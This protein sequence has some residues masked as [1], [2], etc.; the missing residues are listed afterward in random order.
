MAST[1]LGISEGL[2]FLADG[3]GMGERMRAF[4][5]SCSPLGP[6]QAWP[7]ALKTA[8][9]ILLTSKFPMFLAWGPEL[10]FLYNDAYV[11]VLGDKHPAALGHAFEDVW[12]EIW[13]EVGPLARRAL[14]GEATFFENLPL[15]MT[16]KGYEEQTWFTFSYSPLRDHDGIAAGIFCVCTETTATVLA[17]RERINE[18]ERLRQLFDRAPGFMAVV[19]GPNH[20]FEMANASYQRL[21]GRSDLIGK[22]VREAVPEVEGQGLFELLDKVYRSGEAFSGRSVNIS[23]QREPGAPREERLLDFVFQPIFDAQGAV[24]GIF[25]DGYDVTERMLAETAL[26]ESEARFRLIADSAPVPMWVTRLDRKRG[27]VNIAYAEFLGVPYEEALDF[28]WRDRIHP[29]D[30]DQLLAASIAGEAT[31]KLFTLEGRYRRGDGEWRWLRSISQPRWGPQGE[32]VGFIGVAIDI[33]EAKEAE[34]ALREVN[35]TLERR[36][37]ERTADLTAA[38]DRLQAEVGERLKAEEALRQAQKMEAVGQLTGGIAHDFNNLLTPIMGGLELIASRVDEPRLKRIAETA[39]ESTRR[40]AKLTGQ[41]LAFSRIQRISMGPVAV[42]EVIEAMRRLLRHTLGGSV[43]IDTRL[44]P[45]AGHGVCD[46]NQ[47]ENAILNLAINARDAMPDGGTLT[48]STD[49]VRLGGQPDHPAGEFVRITVRDTGTGMAADVLARATEP[50]YSTKPLGKGTGLGLAQVYGIAQQAGG[51]LRIESEEGKGT[52]VHM[53]LP[54][55]AAPG[56]E[57]GAA[58]AVAEAPS[59]GAPGARVLVIDDDDDVRAFLAESLEGLGCTVVSAASGPE[60]LQALREWRPDLALIDYA[61]PGMNGAEAARA[62]RDIHPEMPIVFVTGYAESEQLEA[63]LGDGD[64]PV[65]RKPFTLADLA[66]AVEE[67]VTS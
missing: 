18:A 45:A 62:A 21:V 52:A 53:L 16:R 19:R 26:R 55:A 29:E 41:L 13:D 66:A 11:E 34:A 47:L 60:G 15:T 46:A 35:E 27:F 67:N 23:L 54:L 32:H 1:A 25:A 51:T 30:F 31:L 2:F 39:L 50:F 14:E 5:W 40:G 42:N 48:I 63:A 8:T 7:Q 58:A 12:A 65:L 24:S 36:V 57:A 28:D 61:M 43:K 37:G 44:D 9:G 56:A 6:P 4:D 49:R 64:V 59:V 3:G 20:V 22:P 33:T 38:L 17:E 10:R